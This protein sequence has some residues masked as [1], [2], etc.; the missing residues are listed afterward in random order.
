MFRTSTP[1]KLT[2]R[3]LTYL[4]VLTAFSTTPAGAQNFN[5]PIQHVIVIVQEN[6][7]PDNLFGADLALI[8]AGAHLVQI[9]F[10][11]GTPIQLTPW[12]LDACFDPNHY[13]NPGWVDSYDGGRMDGAC[14]V[15]ADKSAC[16]GSQKLP[17]CQDADVHY[18][19]QYTIVDNSTG[20]LN[21][22]FKLAAQ[23]GFANYM[24]QTNQG[25]SF[26]AHQFLFSGSSEPIAPPN[27]FYKWFASDDGV[28]EIGCT[29]SAD[30]VVEDV[31][32]RNGSESPRYTPPGNTAGFPCYDHRTLSDVLDD[33]GI[34]WSYYSDG[35]AAAWTA[36][37]AISHICQPSQKTGGVCTG[38]AFQPGGS[39]QQNPGQVLLDLG[40]N[41][42]GTQNCQLRQM[43]WVI[44]DGNW[45][46]H[47]GAVGHD[48][49]PSWVA[50]I[51]N[52]VGGY[53][54]SGT[55]LPVQCNYWANT[56]I[57]VTWD[58]WGGFYDDVNPIQTMGAGYP[59]DNDNGKFYV[60]GFRVPLLVVS[61][62]AKPGYISG[63][64]ANPNC[65][66]FYC[67]DFGSI[68]NF[69]EYVFGQGGSSLRE[70]GYSNWHY[71]DYFAQDTGFF[72][73]NYSLYD[74]FD[75][76]H[77]RPFV[78]ITGAKYGTDCFLNPSNCFADFPADPDSDGGD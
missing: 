21:P 72:F 58:D 62:F 57:L 39:V 77:A 51:V 8:A 7:T 11:K 15:R 19:P 59:G 12:R 48:G 53:Y 23:Y 2:P 22:Y 68:L 36:P 41:G 40:V 10:C 49:G 26:P 17:R 24:F 30:T 66:N 18:C 27:D 3:S 65:P 20:L 43:S 4:L 67:H 55:L 9:G 5:T 47:P 78:P 42:T 60:Y 63:P 54:N 33:S 37:K 74:F 31:N 34:S 6:R 13:H 61:P 35:A 73:D 1:V 45:S 75:F 44:P 16:T 71:A 28:G 76:S 69:I 29:A 25:P 52:A 56:A 70:V 64:P 46:D 38:S 50:A 14:G 32:P